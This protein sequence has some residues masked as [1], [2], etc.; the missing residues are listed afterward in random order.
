MAWANDRPQHACYA[1]VDEYHDAAHEVE[2]LAFCKDGSTFRPATESC[3]EE[4][5]H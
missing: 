2:C 4:H 1:S 3:V 5:G